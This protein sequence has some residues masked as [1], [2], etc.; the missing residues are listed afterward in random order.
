LEN[1]TETIKSSYIFLFARVLLTL[2]SRPP[3]PY[4]RKWEHPVE[5][6][7]ALYFVRVG[8]IFEDVFG[9]TGVFAHIRYAIHATVVVCGFFGKEEWDND[10]HK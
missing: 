7:L 10:L 8:G 9:M 6:W 5:S 1:G 4:E 3:F 2:F